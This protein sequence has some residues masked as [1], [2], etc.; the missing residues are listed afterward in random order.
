MENKSLRLNIGCG[1]RTIPGWVNVDAYG[2][3]DVKHDLGVFPWPF[4]DDSVDEILASHI[5][6]HLT[7]WWGAFKECARILK[8]GGRLEIRVPDESS[9]KAATYRDHKHVFSQF[10][11]FGTFSYIAP[12]TNAWAAEQEI[13]PM[14][15]VSHLQVPHKQYY[16]MMHWPFRWLLAFCAEHMRNFIWEQRFLWEKR[17]T[18]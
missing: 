10:S 18:Q 8:P 1:R 16:W 6:E 12:G 14:G 9:N 11:F 15:L 2:N 17:S 4:E 7:D 3:P 5:L 13:L